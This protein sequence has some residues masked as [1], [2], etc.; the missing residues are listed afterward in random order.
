M[1]PNIK[2]SSKRKS[3]PDGI[4]SEAP[5]KRAAIP[6]T[7]TM[8]D[9]DTWKQVAEIAE[10]AL[11]ND[12]DTILMQVSAVMN[13]MGQVAMELLKTRAVIWAR[14]GKYEEELQDAWTM[15]LLAPKNSVGYICAGYRYINQGFQEQ[16]INV[17]SKGLE[18]VPKTDV[19]YGLLIKGKEEAKTRQD[20]RF[21]ILGC[22]PYDIACSI[23]DKYF[24]QDQLVQYS[25]ICST[26]RSLIT[27]YPKVWSRIP[28]QFSMSKNVPLAYKLLPS[29]GQ[30]IQELLLRNDTK[31]T[32]YLGLIRIYNLINLTSLR[33]LS[34]CKWLLKYRW[35]RCRE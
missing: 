22:L 23:I 4:H 1:L 6:R 29:I 7:T 27:N 20:H 35:G 14:K 8:S 2:S 30:H 31:V 3:P 26:W 11:D 9:N 25:R 18:K 16:A 10:N 13:D 33:I 17:F 5:Q 32:K 34:P 15:I 28:Q 24:S 19:Q 21:D 12:D